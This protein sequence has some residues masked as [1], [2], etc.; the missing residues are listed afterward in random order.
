MLHG[1]RL[2]FGRF[3]ACVQQAIMTRDLG[4]LDHVKRHGTLAFY[5]NYQS[6]NF[7]SI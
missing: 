1:D 7:R 4:Y 3:C 2:L 5:V 6:Y